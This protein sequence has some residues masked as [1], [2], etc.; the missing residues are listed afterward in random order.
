MKS[1][2]SPGRKKPKKR[3]DS[4]KMIAATTHT[5]LAPAFSSQNSGFQKDDSAANR[6]LRIRSTLVGGPLP[7]RATAPVAR[8]VR[9]RLR[10]PTG[11]SQNPAG[12]RHPCPAV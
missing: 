6:K 5:A 7:L 11:V 8:H 12:T 10:V 2:E 4:A 9:D 3:P 1:S